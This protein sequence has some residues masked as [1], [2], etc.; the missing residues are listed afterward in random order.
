MLD[1]GQYI[2][3]RPSFNFF[4][5]NNGGGTNTE[6]EWE[7]MGCTEATIAQAPVA[8]SCSPG[9]NTSG[10]AINV[11]PL[12]GNGDGY[13]YEDTVNGQFT[14]TPINAADFTEGA[15]KVYQE[16]NPFGTFTNGEFEFYKNALAIDGDPSQK[17]DNQLTNYTIPL[18]GSGNTLTITMDVTQVGGDQYFVFDNMAIFGTMGGGVDGDYDDNGVYDCADID[19]LMTTIAA[20]NYDANLDLNND[21]FLDL[22][23]RDLWLAE[24]GE[25][26]LGP[27]KEFLLG[28]ADLSGAVD[29]ADF[30]VW[31]DN[32]FTA[33]AGWCN[34]DF[35]ASGAVDGADFI[36]WNDNKF[37]SS[38]GVASVP[39]PT[40]GLMLLVG[41]LAA[42]FARRK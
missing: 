15:I 29:G 28:D 40:S 27:G 41:L 22:T 12:D 14:D 24:A 37:T 3:S 9:T 36:T 11:D 18:S 19:L 38:D 8:G 35:D 21:G 1:G 16:T 26:E 31:N 25:A 10:D 7:A 33:V 34:A 30:I 42:A 5:N 2:T 6:P 32:K 17:L 4:Y 13:I 23:D 20:G 39:E